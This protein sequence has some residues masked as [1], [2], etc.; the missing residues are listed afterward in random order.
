MLGINWKGRNTWIFTFVRLF[1]IF[2]VAFWFFF[3]GTSKQ[4][5]SGLQVSTFVGMSMDFKDVTYLL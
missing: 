5:D 1:A 3:S 4:P 2:G